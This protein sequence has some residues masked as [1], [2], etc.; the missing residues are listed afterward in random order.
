MD[1]LFK[2]TNHMAFLGDFLFFF[3]TLNKLWLTFIAKIY[4][5]RRIGRRATM[6]NGLTYMLFG[7]LS[8]E[9]ALDDTFSLFT[10]ALF[11]IGMLDSE[12]LAASTVFSNERRQLSILSSIR[13]GYDFVDVGRLNGQPS[14]ISVT[15]N[16][17]DLLT[18]DGE[19][20]LPLNGEF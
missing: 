14:T 10:W 17:L 16:F 4:G 9:T 12:H 18:F 11:W 2:T 3:F 8:S 6:V 7:Y 13:F 5:F 20:A 19:N 1:K 15:D